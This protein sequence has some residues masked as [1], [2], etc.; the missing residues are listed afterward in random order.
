MVRREQQMGLITVAEVARPHR[1]VEVA[2]ALARI[3][4]TA[5]DVIELESEAPSFSRV[6]G[7]KRFQMVFAIGAV[8]GCVVR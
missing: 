4:S 6:D 5:V 8:A 1:I 2:C 3:V 7:E